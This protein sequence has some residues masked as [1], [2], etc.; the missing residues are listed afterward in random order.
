[1]NALGWPKIIA[2]SLERGDLQR[3]AKAQLPLDRAICVDGK[4]NSQIVLSEIAAGYAQVYSDPELVAETA[5]FIAEPGAQRILDAIALQA[6][7]VGASTAHEQKIPSAFALL[8]EED[9][10]RFVKFKDSPAGIAYLTVRP[11]QLQVHKQRLAK[12]SAR[13]VQDCNQ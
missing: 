7:T 2:I 6:R 12:L 11:M 8:S 4:Y 13:V 1:M 5:K 3:S 9:K 10:K